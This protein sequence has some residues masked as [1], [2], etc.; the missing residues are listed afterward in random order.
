MLSNYINFL[1]ILNG[2]ETKKLW[3]KMTH[4]GVLFP[5]EYEYKSLKLIH[6]NKE[7]LLNEEA[8]EAALFYAKF[9]NT[10]YIKNPKFN[11]GNFQNFQ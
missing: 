1:N 9:L 5:D 7:I 4:N 10:E 8:E 3:S 6:N 2:G 11:N